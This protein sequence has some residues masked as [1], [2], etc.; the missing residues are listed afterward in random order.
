[1]SQVLN[2]AL[3]AATRDMTPRA[4]LNPQAAVVPV[5]EDNVNKSGVSEIDKL[6][7]EISKNNDVVAGVESYARSVINKPLNSLIDNVS[8]GVLAGSNEI[9]AAAKTGIAAATDNVELRDS[10][11]DTRNSLNMDIKAWRGEEEAN[12]VENI[13][14]S[15]SK[16]LALPL[17]AAGAVGKAG[18][19]LNATAKGG[20]TMGTVGATTGVIS[21]QET[22]QEAMNKGVDRD[23]ANTA[24]QIMG[25]GMGASV[26]LPVTYP[27]RIATIAQGIGKTS[28]GAV[29][30]TAAM[31]GTQYGAG[32]YIQSQDPVPNIPSEPFKPDYKTAGEDLKV[33]ATDPTSIAVGLAMGGALGGV[34]ARGKYRQYQQDLKLVQSL[35]SDPL[36]Y[37]TPELISDIKAGNLDGLELTRVANE[38]SMTT[39]ELI[40]MTEIKD[41][42]V[43]NKDGKDLDPNYVDKTQEQYDL[44]VRQN[45]ALTLRE[46]KASQLNI[47][48]LDSSGVLTDSDRM[49]MVRNEGLLQQ[50]YETGDVSLLD[51]LEI[52]QVHRDAYL[53][54]NYELE[55]K[56]NYFNIETHINRYNEGIPYEPITNPPLAA[57]SLPSTISRPNTSV[58]NTIASGEG[59]Y[60]S[61]N[62]GKAGDAPNA[63]LPENIT[64]AQI[65]KLQQLPVGHPDRLMAVG[66]YQLIPSTL[67]GAVKALKLDPNT[68][69][70]PEVQ[71]RIMKDY[72]LKIKKAQIHAYISGA[73]DDLFGAQLATAQEFASVGVPA[74]TTKNGQSLTTDRS[75]YAGI[76]NNKASISSSTIARDLK[77]ARDR[78]QAAI[79]EGKSADEAWDIA[80]SKDASTLSQTVISD[81]KTTTVTNPDGKVFVDNNTRSPNESSQVLIVPQKQTL[82]EAFK[83]LFSKQESAYD[84]ALRN[85]TNGSQLTEEALQS[86]A[87]Q[88]VYEERSYQYAL[89][90]RQKAVSLGF[91]GKELEDITTNAFNTHQ[92]NL[93]IGKSKIYAEEFVSNMAI[94]KDK[95]DSKN[96]SLDEVREISLI[97]AQ[98][99][100]NKA[101]YITPIKAIAPSTQAAAKDQS[102]TYDLEPI[103]VG[104]SL[105]V[106]GKDLKVLEDSLG[107]TKGNKTN[108]QIIRY[109]DK[110]GNWFTRKENNKEE[111]STTKNKDNVTSTI[112]LEDGTILTRIS[113]RLPDGSIITR[114]IDNQGNR[115]NAPNAAYLNTA[116]ANQIKDGETVIIDGTTVTKQELQTLINNTKPIDNTALEQF[117]LCA[118]S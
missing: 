61:L 80:M 91:K 66:R 67:Q 103:K 81:I 25:A 93:K 112:K 69:F 90:T 59:D 96:M 21:Y 77:L 98:S 4:R 37:I 109:Q 116:V 111:S 118:L 97:T 13:V 70:T 63:R 11:E 12:M 60:R 95:V 48:D 40:S 106:N 105:R 36:A 50:Y 10:A 104:S 84:V 15:L 32:S 26:L 2:D 82:V 57:S 54:N 43:I 76:G 107:V 44:E 39:R 64:I 92:S 27:G 41:L 83:S 31:S 16:M 110:D 28:V 58:M 7:T 24:G 33:M 20:L 75:Y 101:Q 1:M 52:P 88:K 85:M 65:Q 56:D 6:S 18:M 113:T 38:L 34:V 100:I 47:N 9:V 62:R 68:K 35:N 46:I 86:R 51:Q 94:Y 89:D 87:I 5:N 29:A 117:A 74:G 17:G 3:R 78:Y 72:L 8:T 99:R 73:S 55:V 23:T 14:F 114:F 71:D 22:K 19:A 108:E 30:A 45:L 102:L 53:L 79:K 49:L 115:I 42:A